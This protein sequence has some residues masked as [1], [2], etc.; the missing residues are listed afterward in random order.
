MI[1]KWALCAAIALFPT[2]ALAQRTPILPG[3]P[4]DPSRVC[5]HDE[6]ETPAEGARRAEAL[7]AMRMILYVVADRD[8]LNRYPRW[9]DL[10]ASPPVVR[11]RANSGPAGE[12]ARKIAWGTPEPLPGW[13]IAYVASRYD[14]RFSLTDLRD[15][16]GFTYSSVDP[17]VTGR[18]MRIV[19][20]T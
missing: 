8:W 14:V 16:C 15:P 20:L 2:V 13:G 4:D 7:A 5:L 6:N 9:E 3:P 12:L 1:L 10:A 11:L 19:P 17:N 18:R